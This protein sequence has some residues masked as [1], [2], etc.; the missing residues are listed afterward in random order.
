[1][2]EWSGHDPVAEA[3]KS[4]E[5]F[6]FRSILPPSKYPSSGY[7]Q[8]STEH[9]DPRISGDIDTP[10]SSTSRN[11]IEQ[12]RSQPGPPVDHD[13]DVRRCLRPSQSSPPD[14]SFD[15]S[16]QIEK[17]SDLSSPCH[18]DSRKDAIHSESIKSQVHPSKPNPRKG[19]KSI[20]HFLT[21]NIVFF[22][23]MWRL[24]PS[25]V[26]REVNSKDYFQSV[27]SLVCPLPT[28]NPIT[29]RKLR[30][31]RYIHNKKVCPK[32]MGKMVV[33]VCDVIEE[34]CKESHVASFELTPHFAK[35]FVESVILKLKPPHISPDAFS[36]DHFRK[37]ITI[38]Q[39]WIGLCYSESRKFM[40]KSV[41]QQRESRESMI[42]SVKQQRDIAKQEESTTIK[43]RKGYRDSQL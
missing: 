25:G 13:D 43:A 29:A 38:V 2:Y 37:I 1:M 35:A 36:S 20:I 33:S 16:S 24:I 5:I 42:K 19:S 26:R 32:K 41:K 10:Y 21:E 22:L 14:N 17:R 18:S 23:V 34:V 9:S 31:C 27:Y 39:Q 40:I 28:E 7:S 11:Y 30:K 8:G 12:P 6:E 3:L 15:R 4:G